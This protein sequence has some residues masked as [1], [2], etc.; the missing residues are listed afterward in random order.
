MGSM[1]RSFAGLVVML[2]LAGCVSPP[3]LP[4][5]RGVGVADIIRNVRCELATAVAE[6]SARHAWLKT[7]AVAVELS[8]DVAD[9]GSGGAG[10]QI[11][12]PIDVTNSVGLN[13]D[14][15]QTNRARSISSI[16]FASAL[17]ML[18][19]KECDKLPADV[20]HRDLLRGSLG[21]KTWIARATDSIE[22]TDIVGQTNRLGYIIE[23]GLIAQAG[24]DPNFTIVR[25]GDFELGGRLGIS[26]NRTDTHSLAIAMAPIAPALP[27]PVYVTNLGQLAPVAPGA[28]PTGKPLVRPAPGAQGIPVETRINLNDIIR[29]LKQTQ[30]S[31][32]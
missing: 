16:T 19:A 12:V 25:V 29:S 4:Y 23:F 5:E 6:N 20:A 1:A 24:L 32:D 9:T 7:W 26:G 28:P 3:E 27:L 18:T 21:L 17:A 8:L 14:F 2:F 13:A 15:R 10:G 30:T 22:A 31:N 11:V